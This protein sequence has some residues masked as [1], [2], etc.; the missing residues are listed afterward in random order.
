MIDLLIEKDKNFVL[1]TKRAYYELIQDNITLNTFID[2]D[3]L[4][5]SSLFTEKPSEKISQFLKDSNVFSFLGKVD[6]S[7]GKNLKGLNAKY[8][9]LNSRPK[10]EPHFIQQCFK[11]ADHTLQKDW[12]E[13]SYLKAHTLKGTQLWIHPGS[14]SKDKNI[15]LEY[16]FKIAQQ[17]Y[18]ENNTPLII[19][20]GEADLHLEEAIKG[21]FYAIPYSIIKPSNLNEL[22][23]LLIYKAAHFIS[24]DTGPS[25]LAAALGIKTTVLFKRT[26]PNIWQPIGE[27]VFIEEIKK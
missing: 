14:G 22:K 21:L 13:T 15:P 8:I 20:L 9:N 7:L 17:W 5:F 2:I 25:H 23:T 18:T 24:N 11:D 27:K 19:S 12:K 26:N 10:Q 4:T 16:F 1:I 3:S 6:T